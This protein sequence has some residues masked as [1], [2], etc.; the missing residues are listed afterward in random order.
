VDE[1]QRNHDFLATRQRNLPERHRTLRAVFEHSWALLSAAEQMAFQ[2]M[3]IFEGS[4]TAEAALQVAGV[5]LPV[6]Q[7]LIDKSLLQKIKVES[8]R[9]P[10]ASANRYK[11]HRTLFPYV[12]EKLQATPA[13]VA[14]LREHHCIYYTRFL[15]GQAAALKGADAIQALSVVSAEL[16]NV[17]AA[18]RYAATQGKLDCLSQSIDGLSQFYLLRG[19]L[20]E[21]QVALQLAIDHVNDALVHAPVTLQAAEQLLSQLTVTTALFFNERGLYEQAIATAQTALHLAQASQ[22][23]PSEAAAYHHWGRA[24]QFQ[25]SY[26]AAQRLLAQGFTLAEGAQLTSLCAGIH[27][28]LGVTLLYLGDYLA[29][30]Q[31]QEAASQIYQQLGERYSELRS[32]NSLALVHLFSG[33]YSAAKA[34]YERCLRGFR[35]I[36]DQRMIGLELNNLGAVYYHLGHYE[37]ARRYYM[38]G[39][40]LKRAIGDRPL[41]GLLLA[42][43]GLLTYLLGDQA[44]ALAYS[45]EALA[46]TQESGERDIHAYARMCMGHAFMGL[47]R[48]PEAAAAYRQAVEL[49]QMLAQHSQALEPLAGLAAVYLAAGDLQAAQA[50]I[51]QIVPHLNSDALAGVVESLGIY[52][53]CYRV[54]AA[55]Q[56]RRAM[57][58]LRAGVQLLQNRAARISDA[59]SR[60]SY[61]ENVVAHR[62]LLAAAATLNTDA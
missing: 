35:E 11:I 46:V 16:E 32:Q 4:F 36:G 44:A 39:L 41:E 34:I 14:E 45:Q 52:L 6:I 42:N 17:R 40:T 55:N 1:I 8:E 33:D 59:E 37:L 26:T 24:L 30:R 51:E 15:H 23:I 50:T 48:L 12:D 10:A 25:G 54:L 29:G 61:L 53:T 27:S 60:H 19:P 3:A 43:L 57:T 18:W 21:G 2:K 49:R 28:S 56:D 47:G 22:H 31:H 13:V 62:A 38:D 5:T 7:L 58:V 20:P 9:L